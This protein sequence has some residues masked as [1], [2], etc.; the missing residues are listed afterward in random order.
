MPISWWALLGLFAAL[1]VNRAADCWLT[2]APS[3]CG[4]T[5]HPARAWLVLVGLP[6]LF[7]LLA[8]RDAPAG[9]V[10]AAALFAAVLV[11]L[12]VVDLEQRRLPDVVILPAVALA[13]A[14]S[15]DRLGA[16][17]AAATAFL[18]FLGLRMLGRRLHGP[19]ALG[20]GDVKLAGLIG[21]VVGLPAAPYALLLGVLLAGGAAGALL[22]SG[23]AGRGATLPYGHFL[24]LAGIAML[25]SQTWRV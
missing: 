9:D 12:A 21:A 1:L 22:L 11:L 20:M 18:V 8:G 14:L 7:A 23:R 5:R 17:V 16:V 10:A 25:V 13:V 24:A 4:L 19:A 2:P 6:A 3:A 15:G